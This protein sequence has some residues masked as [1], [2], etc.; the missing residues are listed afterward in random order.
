[1]SGTTGLVLVQERVAAALAEALQQLSCD[2]GS[3]CSG[4]DNEDGEGDESVCGEAEAGCSAAAGG[5][6]HAAALPIE[7]QGEYGVRRS[8][9]STCS[10]ILGC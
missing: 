3:A 5:D 1:M 7:P 10:F 9:W 8:S 2:V 6:G 4:S